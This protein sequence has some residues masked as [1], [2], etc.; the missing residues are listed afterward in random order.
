MIKI[1]LSDSIL[2]VYFTIT[3]RA[4]I[5]ILCYLIEPKFWVYL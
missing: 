3:Y 4:L 1:F 5:I 2:V